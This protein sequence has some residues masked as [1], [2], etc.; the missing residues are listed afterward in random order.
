[1]A[2]GRVTRPD[3]GLMV[4]R[5]VETATLRSLVAEASDG[6]GRSV[7]VVGEAGIGKS[8]LL[9]DVVDAAPGT[10]TIRVSGSEPERK[11]SYAGLHRI[12][13]PL[14]EEVAS[15][16]LPQRSALEVTFGEA[17]GPAPSKF[18][19]GLATLTVL[20]AAA[21]AQPVLCVVDDAHWLDRESID[22]LAFVARRLEREH[23]ALVL[24]SRDDAATLAALDGLDRI[25]L[26]GLS[27]SAATTMLAARV[28]GRMQAAVVESIVEHSNGNPLA[29]LALARSL[30]PQ[31]RAG[32]AELPDPL[33]L[34]SG[35]QEYF[36]RAVAALPPRT[37]EFVLVAACASAD[38]PQ[39]VWRAARA[40]GLT[41]KDAD[42]AAVADICAVRDEVRFSHPLVRSA[43]YGSAEPADR[44]AAHAALAEATSVAEPDRRAWHLA[45]AAGAPDDAVAAELEL[46]AERARARG[47]Y[48]AQ[49]S[50]LRRA[51]E[52]T[53]DPVRALQ[54]TLEAAD[55]YVQ[56]GELETASV[57][58][59]R[60]SPS[61][62][63]PQRARALQISAVI[64]VARAQPANATVALMRAVA[65]AAPG[66]TDFVR[67]CLFDA[68]LSA[69]MA[70][71]YLSGT[72]LRGVAASTLST[73][74]RRP[75]AEA[76]D[77]LLDAF[78][79]RIG[80]GY[81]AA[82]RPMREALDAL[83][84]DAG[85]LGRNTVSAVLL[86]MMACDD[87]W[88]EEARS[89]LFGR[90][91]LPLR[92]EGALIALS[93][94]LSARGAGLVREGRFADA[95]V[96][97]A[98]SQDVTAA[99]GV[100]SEV[101]WILLYAWQ[102]RT[103]EAR[104]LAD[105]MRG[106]QVL[107]L[108]T[109]FAAHCLGILA[110]GRQE[111]AAA[112]DLLLEIY[113][114]DTPGISTTSLPDLVEAAVR[115]GDD[116]AA[117]RA[118]DRLTERALAASTPWALGLLARSRALLAE[119]AEPQFKEALELLL[120]T[121]VATDVA[122]AHLL[123]GEWLRRSGRR[124][125]ARVQ[126]RRAHDLFSTM[127]AD[128]FAERARSALLATGERASASVR[129]RGDA[130]LTPQEAR[131]AALAA[132]GLTNSEIASSLFVTASTVE[133]HMTKILRKTGAT[134]RRELRGLLGS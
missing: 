123:Y 83:T 56:S 51:A 116:T 36:L 109:S 31:Q 93:V 7:V 94:T 57:L 21:Q 47:G 15:L 104:E 106:Q 131:I 19:V 34:A 39:T 64:D 30:S 73:A 92:Q 68:L 60:I 16:P 127:G 22:A 10:R 110:L 125:D 111:Y 82:V 25:E 69:I 37:Q 2:V 44:R 50:F 129:S 91:E 85:N 87:L 18:L 103:D 54:R 108:W 49:A 48:A 100:R 26:I 63:G 52:L 32:T 90:L 70:G 96:L 75:Q 17:A 3:A 130:T 40:L 28:P 67:E 65:E 61:S 8:R 53:T 76:L 41:T 59:Q 118:L 6:V 120:S 124:V 105:Q 23:V 74:A 71:R 117:H 101:P 102:G 62:T 12:L 97:Y 27:T 29:V 58:V 78:A 126:L 5:E 46:S 113:D 20:G 24:A 132:R 89:E 43:I 33:P 119:D 88:D 55:A 14:A 11:M 45:Q 121:N 13:R 35:I 84:A 133:F 98:E 4:G 112:R 38:D 115:S 86:A 66:D 42:P 134:S 114:D 107:G 128:A 72:T 81:G 95:T 122:R 77:H 80:S 9:Q 99:Y 1:M 79:T